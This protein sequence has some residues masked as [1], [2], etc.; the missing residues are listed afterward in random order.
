[1][2][3]RIKLILGHPNQ[4]DK[5]DVLEGLIALCSDEYKDITHTDEIE[6]SIVIQMVICRYNLLGEEMLKS[7]SY[8]GMSFNY[9]T[10]YPDNL[11]KQILSHR[12]I[13]VVQ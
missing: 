6:E 12:K 8:T 13:R 2:L 3:D 11:R 1:M 9:L 5:D 4:D 10:D 7:E